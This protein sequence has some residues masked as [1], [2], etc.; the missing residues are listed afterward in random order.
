MYVIATNSSGPTIELNSGNAPI[1]HL[2]GLFTFN[3]DIVLRLSETV[4]QLEA[5][6]RGEG[7]FA[8][9]SLAAR[10]EMSIFTPPPPVPPPEKTNSQ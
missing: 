1:L 10:R 4:K 5:A 6:L 8:I 7:T 9:T 2:S 3:P